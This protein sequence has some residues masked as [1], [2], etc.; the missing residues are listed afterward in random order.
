M[1]IV[2]KCFSRQSASTD[3]CMRWNTKIDARHVKRDVR[4]ADW[5][6]V[7]STESKHVLDL[8]HKTGL[9]HTST[10]MSEII[11]CISVLYFLLFIYFILF[12]LN[13]V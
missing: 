12:Y 5:L 1:L 9:S 6:H 2:I 4:E 8:Q 3:T 11:L 13:N 10:S 7:S